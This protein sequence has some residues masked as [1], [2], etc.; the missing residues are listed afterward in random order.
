MNVEYLLQ[1][2]SCHSLL[3]LSMDQSFLHVT[4]RKRSLPD[5]LNNKRIPFNN[6]HYESRQ[7]TPRHFQ[8]Q[9]L[10]WYWI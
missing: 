9:V 2:E 7:F 4:S 10:T 3:Y 1:A 8:M 6:R 5:I